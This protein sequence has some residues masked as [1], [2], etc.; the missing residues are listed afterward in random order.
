MSKSMVQFNVT[1][2][3]VDATNGVIHIVDDVILPLDVVG[4]A[5]ANSNFTDLVSTLGAASGDLV[6][7]LQGDGP[8]TVFAPL[9]SAFQ[10][11]TSTTETLDADQLA[12]SIIVPCR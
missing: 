12:K 11:I 8:F 3:D 1:T 5:A 9:N 7:T 2:A 10:A 6:N 4:H